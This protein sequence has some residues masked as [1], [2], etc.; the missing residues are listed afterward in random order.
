MFIQLKSNVDAGKERIADFIAATEADMRADRPCNVILDMRYNGGGDY[1]NTVKFARMLPDLVATRGH[2]FLLTSPNTFSAAITT[3]AHVAQAGGDR[4]TILGEPV[5]DRLAFFS[6]GN[7]GC[8]PN[9]P[10]SMFY[11]TG[12]H[13]YTAPCSDLDVCYWLNY[14]YPVRVKTLEPSETI[15]MSFADWKSGRDR[16][17]ERAIELATS[18]GATE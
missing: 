16:V 7:R 8:L 4:V 9:Y 3:T 18:H 10:V 1:T 17:L 12:R 5:G 15:T 14:V 2:I 13:D 11:Q 6:E